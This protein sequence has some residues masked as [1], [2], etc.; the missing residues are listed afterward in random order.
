MSWRRGGRSGAALPV[1][2]KSPYFGHLKLSDGKKKT[3]DVLIGSRGF[4]TT[5]SS[6]NIVDWR[7]APV[8][9]IYYCYDEGDDYDENFGGKSTSGLVVARRTV[10]IAPS[11]VYFAAT[12]PSPGPAPPVNVSFTDR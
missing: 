9:R 5:G 7:N 8:S 12:W 1:D 11:S 3:R 6:V 4:V 10:G 2:A